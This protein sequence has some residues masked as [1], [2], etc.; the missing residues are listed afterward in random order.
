MRRRRAAA[1]LRARPHPRS[2]TSAGPGRDLR[3]PRPPG[4]LRERGGRQPQRDPPGMAGTHSRPQPRSLEGSPVLLL[5]TAT[6][7]RGL[8]SPPRGSRRGKAAVLPKRD[9]FPRGGDT[10]WQKDWRLGWGLQGAQRGSV[11]CRGLG[12][13]RWVRGRLWATWSPPGPFW[14]S[15]ALPGV[16]G[17][18]E[19]AHRGTEPSPPPQP[20]PV[21]TLPKMPT[22]HPSYFH[23]GRGELCPRRC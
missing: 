20:A 16:L 12:P 22:K 10:S 14:V 7:D 5:P 8:P 11:P 23:P 18:R 4:P 15:S 9:T 17:R 13:A 1:L 19:R 6:R 3:L 21:A 2:A